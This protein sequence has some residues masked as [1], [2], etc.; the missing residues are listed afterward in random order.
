MIQLLSLWYNSLYYLFEIYLCDSS[1]NYAGYF[2]L[3]GWLNPIWTFH[4][5]I[6]R[7]IQ[8]KLCT[9]NDKNYKSAFW[10]EDVNHHLTLNTLS[11]FTYLF[12]LKIPK[13]FSVG[14]LRRKFFYCQYVIIHQTKLFWVILCVR[15]ISKLPTFQNRSILD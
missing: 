8:K 10:F 13:T 5:Q 12:K 11:Y 4:D 14:D 2:Y 3:K 7:Y 6:I 15:L 9:N 1:K